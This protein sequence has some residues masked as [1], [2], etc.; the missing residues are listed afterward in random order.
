MRWNEAVKQ[1][2]G[3]KCVLC[4]SSDRLNAHHIK[5]VSLYP[6]CR[7][8]IDNGITLCR[9]CHLK[10]HGAF[11][12]A[13]AAGINNIDPDPEGRK[14]AHWK[15]VQQAQEARRLARVGMHFAW[16]STAE[17]APIILEAARAAGQT[18]N[19]YITEAISMRLASD[20]YD[21]IL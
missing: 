13:G 14:A 20:G 2:D 15:D 3:N 11:C 21:S 1:R 9:P 5:P 12:G 10:Q 6:E 8:D 4:G 7:N 18:P 19:E 17:N 16:R